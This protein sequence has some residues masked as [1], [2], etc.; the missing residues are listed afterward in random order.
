MIRLNKALNLDPSKLWLIHGKYYDLEP[1]MKEHP[2][3]RRFLEQSRGRDCTELFES[4][5][6]HEKLPKAM[7]KRF[8]VGDCPDGNNNWDWNE[9]GFYCT[10]KERVRAH[11]AKKGNDQGVNPGKL[12]N[13]HHGTTWFI[14]RLVL[15][16][17][18]FALLSI[19]ALGYGSWICALLWGLF[20]FALGGYGH[21]AMHG[22]IFKSVRSN[23]IAALV[24]DMGGMS[25]YVFTAMHVPVHHIYTNVEGQDPD[26]EVHFPI[27]RERESQK[28][29]FYHRFQHWY[30]WLI[31]AATFPVSWVIDFFAMGSGTW[32][33][34]WGKM[35][36]PYLAETLLFGVFKIISF[37]LWYVLPH[38]L[39]PWPTALLIQLLM[40]GGA[41][42]IVQGTFAS[43]HQNELAMNLDK[44]ISEHPKDWGAQQLE[45]TVDFQHGHWFPV[46]FSGGLGYQIEHH[47]FPTL[48]YSRL[49]EV[50][51]IVRKTC[52]EF[53]IP[54]FYFPTVFHTYAAHFRFLKRM[55]K[56]QSEHGGKPRI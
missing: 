42:L 11:F 21:E 5:H 20:V 7:M 32:I 51:P 50:A 55:G 19:G 33:G 22:G 48:S 34:P 25:S 41:G 53:N 40:L 36:K 2:G 45:T 26:I 23:R 6:L 17:A 38:V 35:R 8:F 43:S 31:Y 13:I 39:L 54:Y 1:F 10:L 49:K 4:I 24:L 28:R 9:Q 12:R 15:I 37:S 16:L 46:T 29:F 47:L 56:K 14:I 3:G 27:L 52:E 44:R 30:A 18:V